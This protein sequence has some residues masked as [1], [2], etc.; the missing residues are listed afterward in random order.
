MTP[1][2][3]LGFGAKIRESSPKSPICVDTWGIGGGIWG[4]DWGNSAKNCMLTPAEWIRDQYAQADE[5]Y[6]PRQSPPLE[7]DNPYAQHA[8]ARTIWGNA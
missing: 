6:G 3:F 4:L 1:N 8:G 2:S 7:L 5:R